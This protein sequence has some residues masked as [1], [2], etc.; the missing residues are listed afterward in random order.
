MSDLFSLVPEAVHGWTIRLW[1]SHHV[2]KTSNR[3]HSG[4]LSAFIRGAGEGALGQVQSAVGFSKRLISDPAFT[5]NVAPTINMFR[6]MFPDADKALNESYDDFGKQLSS[7]V[8]YI[9]PEAGSQG[10]AARVIHGLGQFAPAIGASV[11][12]GPVVGAAAAAGSTYEQA[13]Q[14]L[15]QRVLTNRPHAPWQLNKADSMR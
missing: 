1:K 10:I 3:R 5:D 11:I 13:Y 14:M 8:E 4:S 2:L 15:W 6:V 9:K 12:G 7:A